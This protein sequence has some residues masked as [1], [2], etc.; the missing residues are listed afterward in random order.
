LTTTI[1]EKC[2]SDSTRRK[3]YD[4]DELRQHVLRLALGL[5]QSVIN[6]AFFFTTQFIKDNCSPKAGL[7]IKIIK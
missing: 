7:K 6:D 4:V 3:V 5:E 2:S 1:G